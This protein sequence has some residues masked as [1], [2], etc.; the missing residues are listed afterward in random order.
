MARDLS[1]LSVILLCLSLGG[2]ATQSSSRPMNDEERANMLL[3]IANGALAER[4]AIGALE[5]L[6]QA[7]KL[8]PDQ[9][10]IHHSIA[11]AFSIKQDYAKALTSAKRAVQLAPK[12]SSAQNTLGRILIDLGRIREAIPPLKRAA[13]DPLNRDT[14]KPLTNL[15]IIHYRLGELTAAREHLDRAILASPQLACIAH[16]YRGHIRMKQS[17]L[18]E[19]VQD[20]EKATRQLCARFADAHLAL[21]IAFEKMR[22]FDLARK[23]YLEVQERYPA[24]HA[25]DQ[26]IS[27]LRSLP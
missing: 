2:C 22:R 12:Y 21:G 13:E 26:A 16:Y 14:Y 5:N 1:R 15:G 9:A 27:Q 8:A 25:A 17:L 24:T 7:E 11:I 3:E 6:F 4:D 18:R 20:Y 19:A 23:K 10:D